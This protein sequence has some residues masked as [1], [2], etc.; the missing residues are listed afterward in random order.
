MPYTIVQQD[1]EYCVYKE[2]DGQQTGDS[3]GCHASEDEA[4]EQVQA[5]NASED[6]ALTLE[7]VQSVIAMHMNNA[8]QEI[9]AMLGSDDTPEGDEEPEPMPDEDMDADTAMSDEHET[10]LIERVG[11]AFSK[12]L[13]SEPDEP[14]A[15]RVIQ[16][17]DGRYAWF[18]RWSNNFKDREGEWF[19]ERAIRDYVQR[20]DAGIVPPPE[21]W[22]IHTPGTKHGSAEL[23]AQVGHFVVSAGYFDD[24]PL[25]RK[26][27][28]AYA[29]M[30]GL[31]MSHGFIF[32]PDQFKDNVYHDFNTFEISVLP[33]KLAANPYTTFQEIKSMT[34]TDEK[35]SFLRKL[36]GDEAD[37]II[38]DTE[39]ASKALE[40]ANVA[41]KD[42][43]SLEDGSEH[44]RVKDAA[45]NAKENF[46][47]LL[48]DLIGAQAELANQLT[49]SVKAYEDLLGTVKEQAEQIKAL[50]SAVDARPRMA[51]VDSATQMKQEDLPDSVKDAIRQAS[52]KRDPFFGVEVRDS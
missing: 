14:S 8:M 30:K 38:A 27:A 46:A 17:K 40:E 13:R 42:F 49:A 48:G 7:D 43:A 15:F 41:F 22:A 51:S 2:E 21:L 5:L 9:E 16:T 4:R 31:A 10:T 3:L 25:G 32:D 29:G 26:A 35:R 36:F 28:E 20:V 1:E 6:K 11:K 44:Q 47:G 12:F 37:A 39:K 45:A 19:S 50:Q 52:V 33:R 24:T 23:V 18:A 34:L